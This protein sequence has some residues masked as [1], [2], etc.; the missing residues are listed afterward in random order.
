MAKEKDKKLKEKYN[1]ETGY[2]EDGLPF[3]R[4]GDKPRI[5]LSID[6]LNGDHVPLSGFMLKQFVKT[7]KILA[8]DYTI[9]HVCRKPNLPDDYL[10][11]NMADD[12]AEMIKRE[13]KDPVDV[14]G[15]ST[16]GQIAHFLAADYPDLV[17]K[18]VIISAAYRLSDKGV[19]IEGRA[20]KYAE[21]GK[22]GKAMATLIEL[23]YPSG[24]KRSI[25][26]FFVRLLGKMMMGDIEYP[27]DYL[28][29]IRADRAMNFKDRLH[30]IKAP[31]LIVSGELDVGYT[32]EDVRVTAEGIPNAELILYEGYGHNLMLA[33]HN[34]IFNDILAFL[35]KE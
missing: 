4:M 29:E 25:M 34:Q 17:R 1:I 31:T 21:Q 8:Q 20:E 16:G 33:N 7:A 10:M 5:I 2:F 30:E 23:I 3:T 35:R 26:K 27:N 22:M 6:S 24:I 14:M 13:F 11:N 15:A 18:L 28:V 12:Y 32:A 19:E 9:Y